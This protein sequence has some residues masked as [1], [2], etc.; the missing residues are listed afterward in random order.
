LA[1]AVS[2]G[3]GIAHPCSFEARVIDGRGAPLSE[4]R[5]VLL[6]NSHIARIA[7]ANTLEDIRNT[8]RIRD[9]I[10]RGRIIDRAR[11]RQLGVR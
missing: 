5:D 4:P 10:Q 3:L 6:Q 2:R 11:L 1:A 7:P 9:V 8:R